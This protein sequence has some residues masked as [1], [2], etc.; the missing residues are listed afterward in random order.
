MASL[1]VQILLQWALSVS[2]ILSQLFDFSIGRKMGLFA[3]GWLRVMRDGDV[4]ARVTDLGSD[5][6]VCT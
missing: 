6:D 3:C 1:L 4:C 2:Q 5:F